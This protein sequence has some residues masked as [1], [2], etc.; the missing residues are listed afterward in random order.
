MMGKGQNI[1]MFLTH[2][3]YRRISRKYRHISRLDRHDWL[4]VLAASHF[5]DTN[6]A[7]SVGPSHYR[8]RFSK[9]VLTVTDNE[10]FLSIPGNNHDTTT[11]REL[12]LKNK[13]KLQA[14]VDSGIIEARNNSVGWVNG[15]LEMTDVKRMVDAFLCWR[16]PDDFH[17]DAGI[18]FTPPD[19]LYPQIEHPEHLWPSGTNLLTDEQATQMVKAMLTAT[20]HSDLTALENKAIEYMIDDWYEHYSRYRD[21][22][23][24]DTTQFTSSGF[25]TALRIIELRGLLE[26]HETNAEWVKIRDE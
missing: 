14:M 25:V 10:I 1:A 7:Y 5:G 15:V 18:E 8:V 21:D 2:M 16:L 22:G 9:D 17:P 12:T 11:Y 3:G 13:K 23:W 19:K 24:I 26:R 6:W 20:P 4:D